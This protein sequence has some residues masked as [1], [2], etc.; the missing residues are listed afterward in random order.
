MSGPKCLY[1]GPLNF[2]LKMMVSNAC[3]PHMSKDTS[4][5]GAHN[6]S[7]ILTNRLSLSLSHEGVL[8]TNL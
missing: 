7:A 5:V 2:I 3:E 1:L 8:K 6:Q 4:I